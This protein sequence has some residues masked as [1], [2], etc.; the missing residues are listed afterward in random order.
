LYKQSSLE[1]KSRWEEKERILKQ[2][3]DFESQM[4]VF[5]DE[6]S[7]ILMNEKNDPNMITDEE[8]S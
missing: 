6:I 1:L 4:N 3:A 2:F 7:N 8:I 5:D